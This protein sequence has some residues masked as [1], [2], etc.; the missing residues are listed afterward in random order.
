MSRSRQLAAIMFT[1]IVGYTEIMDDDEQ[2]AL[3]LLRKNRYLQRPIIEKHRGR[4]L[5]EI[6]DGILASFDSVTEAVA[7][8]SEIQQKCREID[9]LKLRIGIH[10][11]EVIFEDGDV[12]GSGVNIASRIESLAPIGGILVSDAVH[13]NMLNKSGIA[14]KYIG[15]KELKGV[16]TPL[17]LYVVSVEDQ[18]SVGNH[19]S[20]S[21]IKKISL[22]QKKLNLFSIIPW[23]IAAITLVGAGL[24]FYRNNQLSKSSTENI[25]IEDKSI[26]VLPF[27]SLS[28]DPEKQYLADGVMDAILLHLSK[29]EN[30][31][32]IT[33]TSVEKYRNAKMSLPEIAEELNVGHILEGS[34]Q[35]HGDQANLIVQLSNADQNEDHLWANEYRRNW[36]NIFDVQSEVAKSI[37]GE[38]KAVITPEER[39]RIEKIP[40]TN[41]SAYDYYQRGQRELINFSMYKSNLIDLQRAENF[42]QEA[43]AHDSTFGE[44]L[45]GLANVYY[46]R[47]YWDSFLEKT[48]M[49][50]VMTFVNKALTHD[51]QLAE[52]YVMRGNFFRFNYDR[53]RALEEYDK[54]IKYNPNLGEAY[55]Q[56]GVLF[57]HD[58][59]L[60][61]IENF[62][63]AGTLMRG[64]RLSQVYQKIGRSYAIA[65]FKEKGIDYME[66]I[67]KRNGDSAAYFGNL[68]EFEDGYGNPENAIIYGEKSL[69]RDST[70]LWINYL[71]GLQYMFVG[72]KKQYLAQMKKVQELA[73]EMETPIPYYIFRVGYAYWINGMRAEGQKHFD[74][75]LKFYDE[76]L[77]FG[78][79]FFLDLHTY[80]NLASI[81]AFLGDKDKAFEYLRLV[82]DRPRMP[83]WMLKDINNDPFFDGIREEPEFGQIVEDIVRK[84]EAEHLRVKSWLETRPSPNRKSRRRTK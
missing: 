7:A 49:D 4:W 74:E 17:K 41:L 29:I 84:H 45:V 12:F 40:T 10:Q 68:L 5:K 51:P 27:V 59:L 55:W 75:G 21:N 54:A 30:L 15:E 34:F 23:T 70:N 32:V 39:R 60:K 22:G 25:E 48:L 38:L 67:L 56:K 35:K 19:L 78:R 6:G 18:I 37:A 69:A 52:A 79:H 50:S 28:T 3:R 61:A 77:T 57:E 73:K 26:A 33:R 13:K 2:T 14:S 66:H 76:M 36:S 31:R 44:A 53:D 47:H 83:R 80:Y 11:G 43:I 64:P 1:D 58:D 71:M 46:H 72:N 82:N 81:H 8:A 20:E 16:K 62:E 65:G 24:I 63:K 42:F 9:E